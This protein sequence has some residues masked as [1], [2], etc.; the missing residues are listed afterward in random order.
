M[1]YVQLDQDWT[2]RDGQTH[3]AGT[4]V[5]VDAATLARLQAEGLVADPGE[6]GTDWVGPTGG[7]TDWVGP[8]G[9]GGSDS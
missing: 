2:D 5:D 3:P 6:Y 4:T 1:V 8:T 9:G 7:T